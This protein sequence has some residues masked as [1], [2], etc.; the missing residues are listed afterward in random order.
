MPS[1]HEALGLRSL[2][3]YKPGV[4]APAYN[5]SL[6]EVEAGGIRRFKVILHYTVVQSPVSR[7]GVGFWSVSEFIFSEDSM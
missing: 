3:P 6:W 5:P 1:M 7:D 4:V 2:A